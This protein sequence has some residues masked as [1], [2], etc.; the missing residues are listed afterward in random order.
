MAYRNAFDVVLQTHADYPTLVSTDPGQ[1]VDQVAYRLNRL[2]DAQERSG[3]SVQRWG[4]KQKNSGEMNLDALAYLNDPENTGKKTLV[5]IVI[6]K[7]T[8]GSRPSWQE[9]P[10]DNVGN[11]W[12][13][14]PQGPDLDTVA[15]VDAPTV[16]IDT[17]ATRS[18]AVDTP[19]PAPAPADTP[20]STPGLN[21]L[22]Q[23]P[24]QLQRIEGTVREILA[25]LVGMRRGVEETLPGLSDVLGGIEDLLGG[26]SKKGKEKKK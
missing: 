19:I 14:P 18:V 8:P 23:V 25:T 20:P 22:G 7:G 1:F 6:A 21:D 17:T 24:L 13:A 26:A 5:D 11:G 16:P 12:W 9:Y 3:M 4:R 2:D 10:G 15:V